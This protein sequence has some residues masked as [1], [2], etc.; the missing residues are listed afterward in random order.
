MSI[1]HTHYDYIIAG[2]GAAGLSLLVNMIQSGRFS[3]K[4]ILLVDK[5][6]K[7]RNDRTWCFWEQQ[8]GLFE[9]IVYRKWNR[10][11]YH[12][13]SFS[14]L[15]NI[16]PYY[17]KMIRGIDFYQYCLRMVAAQH[18]ITVAY[19]AVTG[20]DSCTG[21]STWLM[22]EN[23]KITAEYIFSSIPSKQVIKK[24]THYLQQHFKGWTI[25]TAE[26]LFDPQEATLMDFRV[27]QQHGTTF[28]YVMPFSPN[29][30]LVEYTL[31]TEHL[32]PQQQYDEGL[33]DYIKTFL[34]CYNYTVKEE[35][36]GIIPMTNQR[37]AANRSNIIYIGT[38]GGQTK[39]SSGY[40]FQFIQKNSAALVKG[41]LTGGELHLPPVP[42]RFHFY[43]SVLL[44]VLATGKADGACIFTELF[45]KNPT[46]R[47][48]RFLDNESSFADDVQL[49][50]TLPTWP[51]LKAGVQEL[52]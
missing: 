17:Y 44:N 10:I 38:A 35:E 19:G 27:S 15:F 49:I 43:D 2:A 50:S 13:E 11:W 52:L 30:A 20:M 4:K 36:F 48:F 16:T 7:N 22:V 33:K 37:F 12:G 32:L 42:Y 31:F 34:G 1:H 28:V 47:L 45:K 40:T 8:E 3:D 14:K 29:C 39:P 51:F 23:Q 24:G 26:N 25:E 9:K 18:N 5:E 6:H 46:H 41:L 21:G